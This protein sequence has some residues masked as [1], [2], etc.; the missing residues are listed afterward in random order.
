MDPVVFQNLIG[1][2]WVSAASGETFPNTNPADCRE[3]LSHFPASGEADVRRAIDAAVA[4]L[5]AWRNTSPLA[6]GA[7]LL[8]AAALL[9][10][11]ADQVAQDLTL[12]EG[13][14]LGEAR[15]ETLRAVAI[16]RYFAAQTTEPI[17][18]NYP[19]ANPATFLY[20]TRV[21]VGVVGLITPWNF[22]IAIPV[23]KL[24]PAL[25]FGNTVVMKPA[26]LTPRTAN[27]VAACLHAAG[28]PAGVLNVV[29]GSGRTVGNPLVAD[30]RVNAVS[31]TGSNSVGNGIMKIVQARGG[32]IQCEMG[33]KNP[34]VVLE[35]ANLDQAADL[36]IAGAFRSTGQK[37]TATSRAIVLRSVLETF[38]E[39][40]L[41]RAR[42]LRLGPGIDPA[43][44]MGPQVSADQQKTVLEYIEIGK[45]EGAE[46]L[47]GG[48]VPRE[49]RF[50]HGY[51]VE[52]TVFGNV[53]NAMTIAQEEIFGPVLS[54]IPVE[55]REEALRVANDIPFGLSASVCT[56]DLRQALEFVQGIEAGIVHVNSE[57]AGAEPQVPF[58]G[59]KASGTYMREQGKAARDFYTQLKTVYLDL[60]PA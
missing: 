27:H 39:K 28:L 24:A 25:A 21:P 11:R 2:E 56:R 57:T 46:L 49:E 17:G 51:F 43:T 40:V 32:R 59:M 53:R 12:E 13:K 52:P 55:S 15:G 35:D 30:P 8:K 38:T 45:R 20:T 54:I 50:A 14:T 1:G 7:M 18:E 34:I 31:F 44:W 33:G 19:S 29:N 9:E 3:V 37:C 26:A 10:E 4:A 41:E 58:G 47:L 42:A 23:W 60:P 48:G 6:R 16:L 22:P 36:T 5:P